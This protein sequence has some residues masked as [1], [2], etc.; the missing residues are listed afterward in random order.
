[1][2]SSIIDKVKCRSFAS[3]LKLQFYS[4]SVIVIKSK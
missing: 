4:M 2:C 3:G 1:L